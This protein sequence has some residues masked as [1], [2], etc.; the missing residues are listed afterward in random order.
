MGHVFHQL[1]SRTYTEMWGFVISIQ[2]YYSVQILTLKT[3][4]KIQNLN[5]ESWVMVKLKCEI[6]CTCNTSTVE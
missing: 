1:D 3:P 6:T 2:M 4:F 5:H